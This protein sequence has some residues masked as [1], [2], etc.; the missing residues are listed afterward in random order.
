MPQMSN[1]DAGA[2]IAYLPNVSRDRGQSD[3]DGARQR[4]E[5]SDLTSNLRRLE[6]AAVSTMPMRCHVGIVLRQL[7]GEEKGT[8]IRLIDEPRPDG[9][10]VPAT[11]IAG[12]LRRAGFYANAPSVRR[13]RRRSSDNTDCCTCE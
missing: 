11:E 10:M 5:A 1:L 2:A 13:H 9:T 4:T 3:V 8:L 7:D 12:A 6:V